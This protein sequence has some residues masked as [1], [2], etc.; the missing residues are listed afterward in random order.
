MACGL[1]VENF[2]C[3]AW[4]DGNLICGHKCPLRCHLDDQHSRVKCN[5]LCQRLCP[6]GH[7]SCKRKCANGCGPCP[8]LM[9][10]K[11]TLCGHT[12]QMAC[13]SDGTFTCEDRCDTKLS[14]GH[15]CPLKCHASDGMTDYTHK[16]VHCTVPCERACAINGHKHCKL[17]CWQKCNPC[18]IVVNRTMPFCGHIQKMT[19]GTDVYKFVC[20][21]PCKEL[22]ACGHKCPLQCHELDEP[23]YYAARHQSIVCTEPCK[24]GC[25]DNGHKECKLKCHQRCLPCPVT[26]NR[27]LPRCP[28]WET[29]SCGTNANT[30]S[31]T[32]PCEKMLPIC[33]HRCP[34][35][36]GEA[37]NPTKCVEIRSKLCPDCDE[38][39]DIKCN[40]F[41][42]DLCPN[43]CAM[44][45]L[46]GEICS[47]S[48][49]GC[50]KGL[51][52]VECTECNVSL[53]VGNVPNMY[54][55][56]DAQRKQNVLNAL[57]KVYD[58]SISIQT[59]QL[60]DLDAVF[61]TEILA[62]K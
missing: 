6:R 31:C 50:Y 23:S 47:G 56:S 7:K 45:L 14:C 59:E 30:V 20:Q 18:P 3:K 29:M 52:H 46:C 55:W 15:Q 2:T 38:H 44:R 26:V 61:R 34:C 1:K 48:C 41:E 10:W 39:Y 17:E 25:P 33:D 9:T 4:C 22:L 51:L 60:E 42:K 27:R 5:E 37:C 35:K 54:K 36:C 57:Y 19:C 58:T 49:S 11:K 53:A 43:P 16:T 8:V 32:S 12:K 21:E 24:R 62:P 13:G 28:H 40:D